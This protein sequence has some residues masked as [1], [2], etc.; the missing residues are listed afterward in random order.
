LPEAI[1]TGVK[2]VPV[3]A[4][5]EFVNNIG[6]EQ[7]LVTRAAGRVLA[8]PRPHPLRIP[9]RQGASIEPVTNRIDQS[10]GH[11]EGTRLTGH[12]PSEYR[13]ID[14][15]TDSCDDL[16]AHEHGLLRQDEPLPVRQF[17]DVHGAGHV[18]APGREQGLK[19]ALRLGRDRLREVVGGYPER[20]QRRARQGDGRHG[21]YLSVERRSYRE[22]RVIVETARAPE[23]PREAGEGEASNA[24]T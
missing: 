10:C 7:R 11:R 1:A 2:A 12:R 22:R 18:E 17:D 14:L 16:R 19:E 15:R 5:L 6:G 3:F 20:F 4:P 13:S 9:A 23:S 21:L 24:P 8:L